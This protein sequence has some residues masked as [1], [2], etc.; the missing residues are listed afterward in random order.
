[1]AATAMAQAA[2]ERKLSEKFDQFFAS[3][4]QGFNA[5]VERK[6]RSAE[7][8]RLNAMSDEELLKLGVT[9]DRIPMYVFR[10]LMTI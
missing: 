2:K 7:I 8:A 1:M 6:S 5:Y 10:D 4:G 3:I 9:R